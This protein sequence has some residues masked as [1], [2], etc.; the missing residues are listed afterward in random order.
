LLWSGDLRW[1]LAQLAIDSLETVQIEEGDVTTPGRS[2]ELAALAERQRRER[3]ERERRR[4][5]V[6]RW[7]SP[8]SRDVVDLP[9]AATPPPLPP[10]P[11]PLIEEEAQA[12]E[13]AV[14]AWEQAM[15]KFLV[16]VGLDR[17]P[18]IVSYTQPSDRAVPLAPAHW[19]ARLTYRLI[20]GRIGETFSLPD[21]AAPFARDDPANAHRI[22]EAV[23]LYLFHLRRSGYVHF[24]TSGRDIYGAITVLADLKHPPSERLAYLARGGPFRVRLAKTAGHL[25]V[26]S[27]TGELVVALRPLRNGE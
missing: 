26:V 15:P 10:R 27:E 5:G 13:A 1:P 14:R 21:A 7:Q 25:V 6:G 20:E 4:H 3:E 17:V 22:N 12:S 16:A 9:P 8:R 11:D 18:E 23:S 2:H 19:H 24:E